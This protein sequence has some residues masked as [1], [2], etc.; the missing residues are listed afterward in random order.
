[1]TPFAQWLNVT[2][3]QFDYAILKFF[4]QWAVA[5]GDFFTPVAE[6]LGFMGE[7]SWFTV[8]IAIILLLFTKTRKGG[9]SMIFSVLVGM[10]FT[11]ICIK[12]FVARPRPYV[13][14]YETWWQTAGA[15]TPSEFSFPSG[16]ATA[17]VATTLALCLFLCLDAKKHRWIIAPA[18]LYAI[19]MCA[20]RVYLI[21]HYP[22][23]VLGGIITGSAAAIIGHALSSLLFKAFDNHV[24]NDVCAF[25][26]DSDIRNVFKN[27]N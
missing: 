10:V 9:V 27:E 23:D 8:V 12:N 22:T 24:D 11:N 16:H 4:H 17:V 20:S 7:L 19:L 14:G 18:A 26:L 6:T 3:G 15:S 1:M 2:F 13:M 21:V 25:M 5:A